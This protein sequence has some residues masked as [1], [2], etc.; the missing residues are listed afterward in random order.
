MRSTLVAL[1]AFALLT[2]PRAQ[3]DP[4]TKV[5]ELL[6]EAQIPAR[7]APDALVQALLA[8]ARE[9][10]RS[11]LAESLVVAAAS[12]FDD[13]DDPA[14]AIDALQALL[15]ASPHGL[16]RR[17]AERGLR[18]L[19]VETGRRA[20]ADAIDAERGSATSL[21]VVGPFGDDGDH[22]LDQR[23]APDLAFPSPG[24]ELPGRFGPVAPYVVRRG[25][26]Q[27]A[28]DL[29]RPG[30]GR[31][32][33]FYALH[34]V[35][36]E[37]DLA[38]WLEVTCASAWRATVRG[39]VVREIRRPAER[40][41]LRTYVPVRLAAGV[42]HVVIKTGLADQTGLALRFVDARGE[43]VA[44]VV[45]L[46][47]DRR[48]EPGRSVIDA[49]IQIPP[50]FDDGLSALVRAASVDGKL[51]T[52]VALAAALECGRASDPDRATALLF[53]VA[54][55][56]PQDPRLELAL[57]A[58][59]RACPDVPAD[60]KDGNARR[61]LERAA[62][63]LPEHSHAQLASA[64]LLRGD[65]RIEDSIRLLES[66]ERAGR[67]GR[68]T[69][70]RLAA[71]R[72]QLG[73]DGAAERGMTAWL[74][75]HPRD[76][77]VRRELARRRADRG[78]R[79]GAL[80]LLEE[81]L[82][83]A[84]GHPALARHAK[85]FAVELGRRDRALALL[86][87][88]V[89]DDPDSIDALRER[90]AALRQLAD[91]D[92]A[93]AVAER[94]AA[95]EHAGPEVLRELGGV[96]FRDGDDARARE[97]FGRCIALRPSASLD[98]LRTLARLD[99][100]SEDF[101]H[102][103]R[104]R[105]DAAAIDALVTGYTPGPRDSAAPSTLVLD[106]MVVE[107]LADGGHIEEVQ[108]LRRINDLQGVEAHEEAGDAA[109]AAEVL[110]L[111]TIEKDGTSYVPHRVGGTF[112]MP[113][114]EPGAFVESSWRRFVES[115]DGGPWRGPD[116]TFQSADEPYV[117][118]ELIVILPEGARGGLEMR[119]LDAR[120]ERI[121]LD[122]GR[123]AL[124]LAV[125][126]A[127]RLPQERLTPP[128]ESLVPTAAFGEDDTH[129]GYARLVRA[130]APQRTRVTPPV[131]ERA[132]A[133][134]AGL[135]GDVAKIR[136][137]HAFVHEH[138]SG[139]ANADA[140][141]TLLRRQGSRFFLEVALLDAAGILL[142]HAVVEPLAPA[143]AD[144]T[145]SLFLGDEMPQVPAVEVLPR[146]GA[147][148]WLFADTPRYAPLGF[149]PAQRGG[150]TLLRVDS[151]T[152]ERVPPASGRAPGWTARGTLALAADDSAEL[153]AELELGDA[154]GLAFAQQVRDLDRNRRGL[155]ARNLAGQVFA[156]WTVRR[157][158]IVDPAPGESF[159]VRVR[160]LRRGAI[161]TSGERRQFAFP[162]P[163]SNL[164]R[165]FGD[166]GART[167]PLR[168]AALEVQDW[169][170]RIAPP[171]G[172]RW[173]SLPDDVAFGTDALDYALRWRVDGDAVVLQRR[174]AVRPAAI[175]PGRFET[176]VHALTRAD[177]AEEAR[178]ELAAR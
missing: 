98:L 46:P 91:R 123:V 102:L 126:D 78:D 137:I 117:H 178:A 52:T 168:V 31:N 177:R 88:A 170:L 158:E 106:R 112:A 29:K 93:R 95:H 68:R 67:A 157:A 134:V 99:G 156:G 48:H 141:A 19:L 37:R 105:T 90:A 145:P 2:A 167:L 10:A 22:F 74:A 143:F 108:Q 80:A 101:P 152:L 139:D 104:F 97:R 32:G 51:A 171:E 163:P 72:Q 136:A 49:A 125:D 55:E 77:S 14:V 82:T 38:A 155:V 154:Q 42:N 118:S 9:H 47:A 146:D 16:A 11:P 116:F 8:G 110:R 25:A 13:L 133:L 83:L 128:S 6:L 103:A 159:R 60:F 65:D 53:A 7:D 130:M 45:E 15:A 66:V 153:D 36:A 69:Q 12:T 44:G 166:Q 43:P 57:A 24:E 27:A 119:N 62:A 58:A 160:C 21:L 18:A 85:G 121:E 41:P 56:P 142:N 100:A 109:S 169:E 113:R 111:R 34:Q 64:E 140:T 162:L 174:V 35:S 129:D 59:W 120:A 40:G 138:V 92:A 144:D 71:L 20:A 84:P 3:D 73:D 115:P 86:D 94:I 39:E 161:E 132:E 175:E 28:L 75:A 50:A 30:D 124:R 172:S 79:A 164:F 17:A 165:R 122:D 23:F 81:G 4:A 148:L 87:L 107:F 33:C 114:L 61:H 135:D 76:E 54:A 5:A 89:A 70:A 127:P 26:R 63:A 147:P 131:R 150:A 1:A 173:R 151:G 176:W 149:V 96:A